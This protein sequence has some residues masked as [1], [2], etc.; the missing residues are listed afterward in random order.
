MSYNQAV[1]TDN[2]NK[3]ISKKQNNY[4]L[5]KLVCDSGFWIRYIAAILDVCM[6]SA[7]VVAAQ[8]FAGFE[9]SLLNIFLFLLLYEVF[10]I[11]SNMQA[12]FA[13]RMLSVRIIRSDG[14]KITY[15]EA[16][17]RFFLQIITLLTCNAGFLTS[18][19]TKDKR[20]LH[21]IILDTKVVDDNPLDIRAGFWNRYIAY[22]IDLT[23][24][25]FI[26][27]IIAKVSG[28]LLED[29]LILLYITVYLIYNT[30]GTGSS[31]Q[32]TLG[33]RIMA[34]HV[35][36]NDGSKINYRIAFG[37]CLSSIISMLFVFIG[38]FMIGFTKS[39]QSLHDVLAETRVVHGYPGA[40][41]RQNKNDY[42]LICLYLVTI[43]LLYMIIYSEY[44][45]KIYYKV[46][47][48]YIGRYISKSNQE[49][50]NQ[51]FSDEYIA[52]RNFYYNLLDNQLYF[53]NDKKEANKNN[54]SV[55]EGT[56][57]NDLIRP[58]SEVFEVRGL[59]GDD[60]IYATNDSNVL[61]GDSGE[62]TL[63]GYLGNDE[64]NGGIGNDRLSGYKGDD[65]IY[66][67]GGADKIMTGSSNDIVIYK[68]ISDS[69]A[70]KRDIILD[71]E[72]GVDKISFKDFELKLNPDDLII[73]NISTGSIIKI[74]NT[75]FEVKIKNN[76]KIV[77][78]DF[79]FNDN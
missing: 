40:I 23:F 29:D 73:Q 13:M 75:D 11:G 44:K 31:L 56:D 68:N 14:K 8:Y 41:S 36:R 76:N 25:L 70:K 1:A 66:G 34:I 47:D 6:V 5:D 39:K 43:V 65:I 20:L 59:D 27:L 35:I 33:K 22:I 55:S 16:F 77:K 32:A 52:R 48:T 46:I 42:R 78:D 18:F 69:N 64:L 74:E 3:S 72:S 30:I 37:R 21:D 54:N 28:L 60:V 19:Y 63:N 10:T 24:I 26:A 62:D 2:S 17:V 51:S 71:F 49:E 7:V 79:I 67:G 4:Q 53:D 15:P 58:D 45:D 38:Y 57:D 9:Y 50:G 12:T 61:Y